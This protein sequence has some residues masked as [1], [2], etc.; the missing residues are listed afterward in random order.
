M[1]FTNS[2]PAILIRAELGLDEGG[3][4]ILCQPRTN[5]LRTQAH[6]VD[7]IMFNT[8]VGTMKIMAYRRS[9]AADFVG[10]NGCSDPRSAN[11]DSSIGF[12]FP[13]RI[14]NLPRNT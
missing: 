1:Q 6:D 9:N 8:L 5:D 12:S 3:N 4:Q 7:I 14:A 2:P 10:G 11:H 13:N